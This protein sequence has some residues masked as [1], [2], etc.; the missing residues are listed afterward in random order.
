M[1][2]YLSV[3][4]LALTFVIMTHFTSFEIMVFV[5]VSMILFKKEGE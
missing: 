1:K 3:I 2:Y 5:G 4:L